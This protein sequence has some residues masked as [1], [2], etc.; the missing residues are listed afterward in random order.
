MVGGVAAGI[1]ALEVSPQAL[2]FCSFLIPQGLVQPRGPS[3]ALGRLLSL[4]PW[5]HLPLPP[6]GCLDWVLW[7]CVPMLKEQ[8]GL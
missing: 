1:A 5:A 3:S 6:H 8:L 7:A 2:P 4:P